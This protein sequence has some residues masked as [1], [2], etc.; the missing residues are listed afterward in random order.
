MCFSKNLSFMSFSFGI[1]SSIMLILFGN[2]KSYNVNLSIGLFFIYVTLMQ[3]VDYLI[4]SDIK[5]ENGLNKIGALIG[6]LLN[7]F[8][9]VI[10]LILANIYIKS[11]NIISNKILY[12]INIIY[13][14]YIFY[15][16]FGIYMKNKMCIGLNHMNHIN[17]TWKYSFNYYFYYIVLFINIINYLNNKNILIVITISMIFNIISYY[18]FNYNIGEFWCLLVTSVPLILLFIQK[19]FFI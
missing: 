17:W 4:W 9:P 3:L 13:I 6:P 16:Y 10:L 7:H 2:S 15:I 19:I 5:C 18:K 12:S 11:N 1:F 14:I 8:Q